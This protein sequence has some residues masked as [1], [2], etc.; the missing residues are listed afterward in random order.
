MARIDTGGILISVFIGFVLGLKM[1]D[2]YLWVQPKPT[3]NALQAIASTDVVQ[4]KNI[5]KERLVEELKKYMTSN[6]GYQSL[7][8]SWIQYIKDYDI[9]LKTKVL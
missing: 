2:N 3:E 6:F 8:V 5:T 1:Q 7:K 4:A 9:F